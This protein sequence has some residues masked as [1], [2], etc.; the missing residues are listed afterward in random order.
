M[1]YCCNDKFHNLFVIVYLTTSFFSYSV[2]EASKAAT[3]K[4]DLDLMYWEK[5]LLKST[6]RK[7]QS[8]L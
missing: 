1:W 3:D 5:I 4:L 7:F 6:G 2:Y 8:L